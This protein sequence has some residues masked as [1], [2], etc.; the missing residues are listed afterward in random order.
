ME[1]RQL[2]LRLLVLRAGFF[3]ALTVLA[4]RLWYLQIAEWSTH[5]RSAELN[6]TKVTW[7]PAPRGTIY[8]RNG[9]AVADNQVVY[10]VQVRVS[11]LPEDPMALDAALVPLARVLGVSTVE[12]KKALDGARAVGALETVLPGLGE[13]IDRLQA[14]R[15]D[16]R[17]LDMP[18]IRA[19][20][21]QRRHYPFGS[22]G[23]HVI[24]YAKAIAPEQLHEVER[25]EYDDPPGGVES[26]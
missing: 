12:A 20:E 23:A 8:D 4:G 3:M 18:G 9:E 17:R 24:G 16:E 22:M 26:R 2:Q 14:I 25:L 7:T 1:P 10:Q 15:L 11:E 13:N 6:R 5:Q 21:A 19:V